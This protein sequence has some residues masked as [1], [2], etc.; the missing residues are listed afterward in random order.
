MWLDISTT[1]MQWDWNPNRILRIWN[2]GT[3]PC[4]ILEKKNFPGIFS[5]VTRSSVVKTWKQLIV[6]MPSLICVICQAPIPPYTYYPYVAELNSPWKAPSLLSAHSLV[7]LLSSPL[8]LHLFFF[9]FHASALW[10]QRIRKYSFN[11]ICL[12]DHIQ[13]LGGKLP[14]PYI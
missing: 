7:P 6:N 13:S 4:R 1:I 11:T 14:P 9:Q 8:H 10:C 2:I 5:C 3:P 12:L